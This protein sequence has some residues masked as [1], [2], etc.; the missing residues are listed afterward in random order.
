ME[1]NP[2]RTPFFYGEYDLS[3]DAKNRLLVPATIRKL[4]VPEIHGDAFCVRVRDRVLWLYPELYYRR[5]ANFGIRP[6]IAPSENIR[7]ADHLHFALAARVEW[8]NQGRVVLP[9]RLLREA[10]LG[11]EVT[12]IGTR[13]HLELWNRQD[14]AKHR[15]HI[16]EQ[17]AAI[18]ARMQLGQQEK[19]D[20]S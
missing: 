10:Q 13:D 4:I 8:D 16:S 15:A 7:D 18:E 1:R 14:W 11:K 12:L 2:L 5:L 20:R 17:R 3:I 19:T 9:D 6:Q